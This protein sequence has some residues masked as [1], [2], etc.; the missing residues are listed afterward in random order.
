[1]SH[2]KEAHSRLLID[3]LLERSGWRLTDDDSGKANVRVEDYL[4]ESGFAD[5]TLLGQNKR[6]LA[7]IEAKKRTIDPLDAKEQA[8]Q[9]ANNLGVRWVILSNGKKHYQWNI[10]DGNPEQ[11]YHFP[12]L[13]SLESNVSIERD[14]NS[15][16]NENVSEDYIALTQNPDYKLDPRW[17]TDEGKQQMM[18]VDGLRF[19]RDYQAQA[20]KSIQQAVAKGKKRFLFEMATGTGKTLTSAAIIKLFIK[21]Q[22]AS[23]VL[24]LVDRLELENQAYKNFRTYLSPDITTYIFKEHKDDWS[25][26]EV[27]VTTIQSIMH[28]NKF[29]EVFNPNDFDLIISDEAHRAI[30]GAGA[31]RDV[32]EYFS[33]YKLGLT[34]TPKDYLKNLDEQQLA[35]SDPRELEK[36]VQYSTYKTFGCESGEPT[37]R[38]GLLDGVKDGYLINPYVLDCRTKVSTQ[39]L[40]EEGYSVA[41]NIDDDGDEEAIYHAR[42]F[43][44]KFFSPSTNHK[45][46][47]LFMDKALRD[48]ISGEI[49][50]TIVFCVSQNHARKITQLF[51]E[52]AHELFP[53]KYNSD[54]AMQITS[55]V[56]DA[57]PATIKFAN[58]NLNGQSKF[59]EGYKSSKTRV[60]VTVGMMTTGYDAPDILNICLMRPIFSPQDFVQIKGRGTRKHSFRYSRRLSDQEREVVHDK[61]TFYLFDFFANCEFFENDYPYDEIPEL[62]KG[63]VIE[64]TKGSYQEFVEMTIKQ[65]DLRHTRTSQDGIK[66]I[67]ERQIDYRGMGIDSKLYSTLKDKVNLSSK[68]QFQKRKIID[69]S[70]QEFTEKYEVPYELM[71]EVR[72]LFYLTSIDKDVFKNLKN[73]E[74]SIYFDRPNVMNLLETAGKVWITNIVEFISQEKK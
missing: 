57:Q 58:N 34:A 51:N 63:K 38:Y 35:D 12:T 40:S 46:V 74:F 19:L 64:A 20:I 31:S 10:E 8:R 72:D 70:W 21:T 23:R 14:I 30:S 27:V 1:M 6:P 9:Y 71:N 59:V 7:V 2:Q 61:E 33:G 49:G 55:N 29:E 18:V 43:E 13:E 5:Y 28:D 16:I 37:F 69:S 68:Q 22:N 53:G 56:R 42:D 25:R 41:K 48:P 62:P 65:E 50:K 26:A 17:Q 11:I 4:T 52:Y 36:R 45:F 39:L 66:T 73:S 60:C 47:E 24:F 32:F 67:D 44:K 15:L 3:K 54:F